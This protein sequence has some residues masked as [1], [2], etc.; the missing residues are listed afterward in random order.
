MVLE[1][2][3]IIVSVALI[4]IILLQRQSA[5]L[6]GAFGGGGGE[7]FHGRRG[8]EKILFRLTITLVVVFLALAIANV[9]GF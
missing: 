6:S 8:S 4:I 9:A 2:A 1:I 7:F 3:Q 5:G